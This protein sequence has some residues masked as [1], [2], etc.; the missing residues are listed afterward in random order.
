MIFLYVYTHW[1]TSVYSLIRR[2]FVEPVRLHAAQIEFD[3]TDQSQGGRI[4]LAHHSIESA[5]DSLHKLDSLSMVCLFVCLFWSSFFHFKYYFIQYEKKSS[6]DLME[7]AP[8]LLFSRESETAHQANI[9][10]LQTL[11]TEA[12][13]SIILQAQRC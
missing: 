1:G 13:I 9:S 7:L 8:V 11:E 12:D 3:M 6:Q 10:P 2:T 4:S 5:T